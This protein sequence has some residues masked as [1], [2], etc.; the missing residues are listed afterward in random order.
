[1]EIKTIRQMR[2]AKE[3]TQ[4]EMAKACE[5]HVNTYISWEKNPK[6]IPVGKAIVICNMLNVDI[7]AVSFC[8]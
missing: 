3:I 6:S 5:V 4:E 2:L 1:M 8:P 7:G